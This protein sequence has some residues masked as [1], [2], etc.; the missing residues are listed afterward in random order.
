MLGFVGCVG[1]QFRKS[2]LIQRELYNVS[3]CIK[4]EGSY[5]QGIRFNPDSLA[6]ISPQDD[7]ITYYRFTASNDTIYLENH[8]KEK[9][10]IKIHG[11]SEHELLIQYFDF[12][13]ELVLYKKCI[14]DG[15]N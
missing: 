4:M 5:A 13:E 8:L 11:I 9:M 12:G 2:K 15:I 1:N 3:W 10:R 7:T 6:I 14:P